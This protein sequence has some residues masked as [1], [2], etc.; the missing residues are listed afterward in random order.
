MTDIVE[1]IKIWADDLDAP[2]PPVIPT[3]YALMAVDEIERLRSLITAWADASDAWD[4]YPDADL[5]DRAAVVALRKAVG[6]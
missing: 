4:A 3:E 2:V 6:R 5:R 1:L